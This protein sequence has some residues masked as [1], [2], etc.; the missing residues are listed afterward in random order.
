[1]CV[2]YLFEYM[3]Y[4]CTFLPVNRIPFDIVGYIIYIEKIT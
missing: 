4:R 2:F 3:L 1:M